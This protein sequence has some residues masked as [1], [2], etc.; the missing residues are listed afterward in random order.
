[1]KKLIIVILSSLGLLFIVSAA[2]MAYWI[3]Q[4]DYKY[5]GEE[6]FARVNSYRSY[7][8]L[9][10]LQ[11]HPALCNNLVERYIKIHDG[12]AHE[13]FNEWEANIINRE[14]FG[15]V[16]EMYVTG[17]STPDNAIAFWQGSQGHKIMLEMEE[18][19]WGC[20]Y[21]NDGTGVVIMASSPENYDRVME[22]YGAV[23][24][25]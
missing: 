2:M 15:V 5:T 11:E 3:T 20:A 23:S 4:V 22:K 13:G 14:Q 10:E 7:M 25:S 12:N 1:M 17:I 16:G 24:G 8:E 9:P 21:A 18:L 19:E 6:L